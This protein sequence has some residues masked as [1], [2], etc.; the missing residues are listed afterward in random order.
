MRQFL[1]IM[2]A[3]T[4][5][6]GCFAQGNNGSI[7]DDFGYTNKKPKVNALYVGP[8]LGATM[9]TASGQP[10]GYDLF[11]GAGIGF[12]GGAAIRARFGK[13]T[14][15][16][17]V[18]TGFFGVGLD[19]KYKLNGVKTKATENLSLGY[20][21]I[22]VIVQYYPLAKTTSGNGF[23]IEAGPDFA[24]LMSKSPDKLRLELN[25]PYPGLRAI[26]YLTG[27]LK[28]GDLRVA[29]GLGYNVPKMGLVVNARYYLGMSELSKNA[30]PTKLNT[31]ELSLSWLF[32]TLTF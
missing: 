25:E 8:T 16:S 23:F 26:E 28:G 1:F 4:I 17:P 32:K 29:L 19:I 5:G 10:K 13:A 22:P 14:P 18:G 30:L 21:E 3:V 12:S 24:L 7:Y 11:D 20:L 9:T 15:N 2:F 27:D 31:A 6:L